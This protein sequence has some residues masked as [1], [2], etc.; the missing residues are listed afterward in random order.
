MPEYAGYQS[1]KTVDWASIGKEIGATVD[2]GLKAREERKAADQKLYT[3]SEK[4]LSTWEGTQNKSYDQVILG[5]L[6]DAR[7]KKLEWKKGLESGAISRNEYQMRI[8]NLDNSFE[9]LVMTTKNFDN[10]VTSVADAYKNGEI[11]AEGMAKAKIQID[12]MKMGN[13]KLTVGD[14]GDMYMVSDLSGNVPAQN[15]KNWSKMNNLSSPK[16]DVSTTVDDIVGKWDPVITSTVGANGETLSVENVRTNPAYKMAKESLIGSI[17][18]EDDPSSVVSVLLDNSNLDYQTYYSGDDV[19]SLVEKAAKIQEAVDGKEM[20]QE[21]ALAFAKDY[22][23][24][25][26]IEIYTDNNGDL[27]SKVTPK[28]VKD[29]RDVVNNKIEARLG[30]KNEEQRGFAPSKGDGGGDGGSTAKN[31]YT[32]YKNMADAW[33][34]G[35]RA[36]LSALLKNKRYSFQYRKKEDGT[37]ESRLVQK[38]KN[39]ITGNED[40]VQVYPYTSDLSD[41]I[42]YFFGTGPTAIAKGKKQRDLWLQNEGGNAGTKPNAKPKSGVNWGGEE[43][44]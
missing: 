43:K 7:N 11:G 33:A 2:Q 6:E 3:D 21:E 13:K 19:T 39:E 23:E 15:V 26:L 25:H 32:L 31:D 22:K 40:I 28:M 34:S 30:W 41:F 12:A 1:S 18:N 10:Y 44:E 4:K 35:D 14:N 37:T 38:N 20:T 24:N 17:V 42:P 8:Q 9:S 27:V 36:A 5:G 16:L 29:A